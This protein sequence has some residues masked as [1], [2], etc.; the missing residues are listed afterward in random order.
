MQQ[1][2]WE[3]GFVPVAYFPAMVFE[4]VERLDVV[5]M[6]RLTVP[7]DL[8]PIRMVDSVV[9]F[10]ELVETTF[11]ERH[12]GT[13]IADVARRVRIFQGLG[14]WDVERLRGICL[15]KRYRSGQSVFAKGDPGQSLFIVV[16]GQAQIVA[17]H[18]S[19]QPLA[20]VG[21]GEVFGEL[22]LVDGLPRSAGAVCSADSTL[23]MMAASD[24][25][26]LTSRHP[27]IGRTVLLNLCRTLSGRLRAA[28]EA[29]ETLQG[30][31]E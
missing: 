1:S 14:D 16:E 12:R 7:W 5:K 20:T 2:L 28:N 25:H 30:A 4:L 23:L 29:I 10:K 6:V 19:D 13:V 24:F 17:N 3:L 18:E 31:A 21:P 27:A 15:E 8:G 9:P 11:A 26:Q 22:S